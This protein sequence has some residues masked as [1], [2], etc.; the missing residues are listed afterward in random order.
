MEKQWLN[1]HHLYYFKVIATEGSISKAS[2]VLSVG[3]PSLSSQLKN[4]EESLGHKLFYRENRSLELTEAGKIALVYAN[5]IFKKGEEFL[6]VFNE[7][8]LFSKTNYR[9]GVVDSVP[10]ILT[11]SLAT[12]CINQKENLLVQLT[13]G[14]PSELVEKLSN[15]MLDI[16]LSTSKDPFDEREDLLVKNLG[17]CQICAYGAKQFAS[18]AKDFPNSLEGAPLIL[19]TKHSKLR[20]DL[21]HFFYQNKLHHKTIFEVQDSSLKKIMAKDGNGVFFAPAFAVESF[22][23]EKSLYCL[24]ELKGVFEEYWLITRKNIFTDDLTEFLVKNFRI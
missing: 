24:G 8:S 2:V 4:L 9:I 6:H 3:Q 7:E 10:K 21:E 13:E 14:M 17:H 11:S 12:K 19:P 18:Y 20:Y 22:L 23:E 1:Y 5:E 16:V 15:Q